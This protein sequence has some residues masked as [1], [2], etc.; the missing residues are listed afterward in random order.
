MKALHRSNLIP[1]LARTSPVIFLI[2]LITNVLIS[3]NYNSIYL[4]ISYL[5]V[6]FSNWLIKNTIVK[7]LYKIFDIK[8]LPLLGIG[9]RPPGAT[10]CHFT[11][12]NQLSTSF[13]MPSGHSQIAWTVAIYLVLKIIR[14]WIDYKKTNKAI[15][16]IGYIWMLFTV[17]IILLCA[18]YISFSRVFIEGCHTLQQ[19]IVGGI[20]G[21]VSGYLI[22]RYEDKIVG[23]LKK[24]IY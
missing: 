11:L 14:K 10:S 1:T 15:E 8:E 7:P 24:K 13:G 20:I 6:V 4:F 2:I 17:I 5:L 22:F 16:I 12:D 9:S 3:P 19:V 21:I 23:Y 18:I